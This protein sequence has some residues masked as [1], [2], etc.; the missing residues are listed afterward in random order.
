MSPA[1]R[2]VVPCWNEEAVLPDLLGRLDGL[3]GP[4]PAWEVVFVDDGSTDRTFELLQQACRR[5]DQISVRRHP[6]NAGLGA[7]LRTGFA[8]VTAPI[9]CTI[10]ADC[11]YPPERLPDLVDAVGQGADL[12]TGSPWHPDNPE[13]EG[14]RWRVFLSRMVSRLY[15]RLAKLEVHTFTCLFRAYRRQVVEQ[16]PFQ[17]NGFA[18]VAEILVKAALMGF[19]IA[20][21]PMP[22]RA[23]T[24]GA[25]KMKAG[26][27]IVAHL[28]LLAATAW[29]VWGCRRPAA[30]SR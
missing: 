20:E 3:L 18:A 10:D 1:V 15:R 22:L 17:E 8:G 7:A 23:R 21:V 19:R 30:T 11:T 4:R 6:S 29:W 26:R 13:C 28:K 5:R 27:S 12:V 14:E 2:I 25:S 16:V 9:V 24:L